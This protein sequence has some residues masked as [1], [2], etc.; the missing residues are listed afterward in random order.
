MSAA[1]LRRSAIRRLPAAARAGEDRRR[2]S[3]AGRAVQDGRSGRAGPGDPRH[4]AEQE[5][6]LGLLV[7]TDGE[8]R[9]LNRPVS[10]VSVWMGSRSCNFDRAGSRSGSFP[11]RNTS[12]P[13]QVR[14]TLRE[15]DLMGRPRP[16]VGPDRV[17]QMC[18]SKVRAAP[19][20]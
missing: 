18:A 6:R 13:T 4:V 2:R 3:C 1:Y 12:R 20:R 14:S 19:C 15:N 10:R 8:Y 5:A 11:L 17:R 9:R 7:V 16:D